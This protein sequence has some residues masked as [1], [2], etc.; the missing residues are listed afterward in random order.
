MGVPIPKKAAPKAY[1]KKKSGKQNKARN[2]NA[3]WK[4]PDNTINL[5]LGIQEKKGYL[6]RD[7]MVRLCREKEMPGVDVYGVATFY[8]QF[9]LSNRGK[10]MLRLCRGT[11]CHVKGSGGLLEY[12]EELLGI[13]PGQTTKDGKFTLQ[14]VNCI[15]ACAR[16]P[17][18]M[19]NDDVYG[20]LDK[21]K[22][23]K[24]LEGLR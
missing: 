8:S 21:A 12:L 6:P 22:L 24:L 10:Y 20:E 7:E 23:R 4:A 5:L 19:I 11:A 15:G 14:C 17:N 2:A 3:A 1:A 18:I 16:A 9:R 13:K